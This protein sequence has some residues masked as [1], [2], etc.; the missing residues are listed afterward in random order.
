VPPKSKV[1]IWLKL[2]KETF[3]VGPTTTEHECIAVH[4]LAGLGRAP[5]LVGI[6]LIE[7]GLQAS[8]AIAMIRQQR[9]GALNSQQVRL[10]VNYK[11]TSVFQNTACCVT[12]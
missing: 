2:V 11:K 10:L 7:Y 9:P 8:E 1:S 12:F 6:A 4:C 5:V 3:I